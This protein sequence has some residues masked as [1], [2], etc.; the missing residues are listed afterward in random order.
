MFINQ[1][2]IFQD[3]PFE[4]TDLLTVSPVF[5]IWITGMIDFCNMDYNPSIF[6]INP[7]NLKLACLFYSSRVRSQQDQLAAGLPLEIHQPF[8]F[9]LRYPPFCVQDLKHLLLISKLPL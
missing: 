9:F 3:Y 6:Q 7:D 8:G 1:S 4:K 5:P 2:I